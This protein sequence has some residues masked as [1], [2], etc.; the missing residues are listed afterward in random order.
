M[1]VG[2]APIV[3][4]LFLGILLAPFSWAEPQPLAKNPRIGVL[5]PGLPSSGGY[6]LDAF[7]QG[8]RGLGYVEGKNIAI[9]FRFADGKLERLPD[10]AAEPAGSRLTS[11]WHR[12]SQG[13]CRDRVQGSGISKG[14][15]SR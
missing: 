14:L 4:T 10:L 13:P 7:R 9:E 11:S 3:L 12:R 6:I 15:L 8:L 2:T 1:K 5:D